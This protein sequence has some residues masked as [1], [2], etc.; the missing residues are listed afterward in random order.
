MVIS[1]P[2]FGE[3]ELQDLSDSAILQSEVN[4][5]FSLVQWPVTKG[6]DCRLA[7][8]RIDDTIVTKAELILDLP[9]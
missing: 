2:Q 6:L 1:V 7:R 4:V 9:T 8:R 3:F 5:A